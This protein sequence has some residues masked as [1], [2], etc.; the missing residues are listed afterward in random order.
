MELRTEPNMAGTLQQPLSLPQPYVEIAHT[1]DLAVRV[2]GGSKAEALARL[3]LA[4]S[5]QLSGGAPVLPRDEVFVRVEGGDL[6]VMAVDVLREILYRFAT[7]GE[8]PDRCGVARFD[9]GGGEVALLV[10]PYDPEI[11][12]G[13]TDIKAVTFHQARFEEVGRGRWEAEVVFDI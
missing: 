8:I 3:V 6:P 4:L 5:H 2:E 9:E 12:R 13:G 10:G 1:A 11:H 7:A